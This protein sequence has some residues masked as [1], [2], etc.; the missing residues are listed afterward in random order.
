MTKDQAS[1]FYTPIRVP[2]LQTTFSKK[3]Y[4]WPIDWDELKKNKRLTQ[5]PGW[6]SFD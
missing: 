4:F 1:L 6:P 3:M 5:A 2:L